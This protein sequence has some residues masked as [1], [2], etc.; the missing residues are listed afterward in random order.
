VRFR[1]LLERLRP[2]V[3]VTY[4]WGAIEWALVNRWRPLV[5]HVHFED[6]FGPEESPTVQLRRRIYLRRIALGGNSRVIVPSQTLWNIVT[7][8]WALDPHRV[9]LIRNGVDC[10][11]FCKSA[12]RK[13]LHRFGINS[14]EL[15]IGT[16]ATLR[17]EKNLARLI[18][19][20]SRLPTD[21]RA[22]LVVAG[23]GPDRFRL[24]QIAER[25]GVKAR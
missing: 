23:H 9:R 22:T 6:G 10:E 4:H 3:L 13:F 20:F 18:E 16:V 25:L 15:V 5:P 19:A 8:L 14:D 24:E 7:Q 11:R 21:F 12:D 1:R 17:P 2:N